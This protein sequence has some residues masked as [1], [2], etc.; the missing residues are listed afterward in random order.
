MQ[1]KTWPAIARVDSSGTGWTHVFQERHCVVCY[2]FAYYIL[3]YYIV[4]YNAI[5]FIDG[6]ADTMRGE[7]NE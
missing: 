4:I 3:L 2:V 6:A 5:G 1:A 7:V